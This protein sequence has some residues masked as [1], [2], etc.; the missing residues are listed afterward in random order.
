M[1]K[2]GH[3]G[4]VLF[5]FCQSMMWLAWVTWLVMTDSCCSLLESLLVALVIICLQ[6]S[7]R[8]GVSQ[9]VTLFHPLFWICFFCPLGGLR[10]FWVYLLISWPRGWPCFFFS[11]TLCKPMLPLDF[12]INYTGVQ[13]D[14]GSI[15]LN[16][17]VNFESQIRRYDDWKIDG[18]CLDTL[19]IT[20]NQ[21]V[22]HWY[23]N[24]PLT[25]VNL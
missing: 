13:N 5:H 17:V 8:R 9:I 12:S 11:D 22:F 15:L 1:L 2:Q 14:L 3:V 16:N 6:F 25:F 20:L 18:D 23:I 10:Y 24:F 4:N 19:Y 21:S 7:R